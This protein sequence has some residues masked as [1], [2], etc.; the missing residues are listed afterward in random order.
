MASITRL[1]S[2]LG[3]DV[4]AVTFNG[5]GQVA[6]VAGCGRWAQ[7]SQHLACPGSVLIEASWKDQRKATAPSKAG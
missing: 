4:V 7:N 6:E 5:A 2:K 1:T 3:H